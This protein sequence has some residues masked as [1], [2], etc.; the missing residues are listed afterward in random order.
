M[1]RRLSFAP[2]CCLL[3][4]SWAITPTGMEAQ[5][6]ESLLFEIPAD[7][8]SA[9]LGGRLVADWNGDLHAA[10]NNPALL[11][12]SMTGKLAMETVDYFAGMNLSAITYAGKKNGRRQWQAGARVM[13]YGEF[14]GIDD[15]GNSTENFRGG[16]FIVLSGWS[17]QLDSTWSIGVQGFAGTRSLDREIAGIIGTDVMIHGKWTENR[18]AIGAGITGLGHQMGLKGSQPSGSLPF[19]F[20]M[21]LCKG[22]A[23]APFTIYLRA[24]H[25]ETWDLAPPG[26]YD[27]VVDPLT[28]ESIPNSTFR[29]G[30]QLM[31]HM[32]LGTEIRLGPALKIMVGF[33]YRRRQEIR[34]NGMLGTNGLAIGTDFSVRRF[35]I[36]I[37]RNTYHFAGSS[38]HVG[39]AFLPSTFRK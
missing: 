17:W 7:A 31:R 36:R 23:N 13:N 8:R 39:V 30:D 21:G 14:S 35:R 24:G 38:T 19:D 37:S 15:A 20:Q 32:G 18:F 3:L 28:G 5:V 27:D 25:L 10:S 22:F 33:D 11:D 9:A 29:L 26:T 2:A 34:A 4:F 16:D 12:S 6:A 1:P